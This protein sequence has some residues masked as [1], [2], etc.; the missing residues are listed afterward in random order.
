MSAAT[1]FF[2]STVLALMLNI[3]E[4]YLNILLSFIY[5]TIT[6]SDFHHSID[7]IN[8]IIIS[9]AYGFYKFILLN[10]FMNILIF[11][12]LHSFHKSMFYNHKAI[13]IFTIANLVSFMVQ[14]LILEMLGF[15]LIGL[16]LQYFYGYNQPNI[17]YL[18]IFSSSISV[19][20][21][22]TLFLLF[23]ATL[24]KISSLRNRHQML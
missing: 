1:T 7:I 15:D 14:I 19:Y 11:S 13:I 24:I 8:A 17:V 20:F 2:K 4:S 23:K 12:I 22:Y 16:Q 5:I 9:H 21:L 10:G 3:T 6:T 18:Y